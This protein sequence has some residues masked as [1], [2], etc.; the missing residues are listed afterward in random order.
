MADFPHSHLCSTPQTPLPCS[1]PSSEARSVPHG[2]TSQAFLRPLTLGQF[3]LH[4]SMLLHIGVADTEPTNEPTHSCSRA[5]RP[6]YKG[7]RRERSLPRGAPTFARAAG[8][9]LV[10]GVYVGRSGPA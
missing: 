5:R 9:R 2:A 3:M 8:R 6:P 7:A 1:R 4:C 10:R